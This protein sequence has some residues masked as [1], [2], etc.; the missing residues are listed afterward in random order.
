MV[1]TEELQPYLVGGNSATI[2]SGFSI[3]QDSATLG[4]SRDVLGARRGFRANLASEARIRLLTEG[5][6]VHYNFF[7][8]R[9]SLGNKTPA[10]KAGIKA[11]FGSREEVVRSG[12]KRT[13]ALAPKSLS[14][15]RSSSST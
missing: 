3:E 14:Q 7:S 4:W 5:W 8:R 2:P 9:L 6:W 13:T 1:V 15:M 10:E 12:S 11:K